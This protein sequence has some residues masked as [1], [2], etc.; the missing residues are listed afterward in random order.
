MN[1]ESDEQESQDDRD[2]FQQAMRDVTPLKPDNRVRHR[3]AAKATPPRPRDAAAEEPDQRFAD[4][5]YEDRCP[6]R[7]YFARAGGA[8]KPVLKKLRAGRLPV[9][10]TLDLHG[11]KVDAA[12]SQLIEF[13]TECRQSGYR[14]VIIIH[15]KGFR[16]HN[17]PV[18]KPM[19]N[20]WLQEANEVLAFCS[21]QPRDGGTG[22]VYVLL[23]KSR[24]L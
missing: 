3:P 9:D 21:A 10:S 24:D 18:I 23:R 19:V 6:D 22:A 5:L 7:L 20:R 11:L 17:K 12:R 8:Q 2:L 16:S 4:T 15:G 14:H 1:D 13:L